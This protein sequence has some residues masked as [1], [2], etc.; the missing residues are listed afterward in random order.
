MAAKGAPARPPEGSGPL[1]LF[2]SRWETDSEDVHDMARLQILHARDRRRELEKALL[3]NFVGGDPPSPMSSASGASAAHLMRPRSA[4][5]G[6]TRPLSAMSRMSYGSV[7]AS[8]LPAGMHGSV[9]VPSLAERRGRRLSVADVLG[10]SLLEEQ[11]DIDSFEAHGGEAPSPSSPPSAP[12]S[13]PTTAPPKKAAPAARPASPVHAFAGGK[14]LEA[15][16]RIAA[17]PRGMTRLA[18]AIERHAASGAE[19]HSLGYVLDLAAMEVEE[20]GVLPADLAPGYLSSVL[21]PALSQDPAET[22]RWLSGALQSL[23]SEYGGA[24]QKGAD[25]A[26]A[27]V[28]AGRLLHV[29]SHQLCA[30]LL[31]SDPA[32]GAAAGGPPR[33]RARLLGRLWRSYA[34]LLE[35]MAELHRLASDISAAELKRLGEQNALLQAKNTRLTEAFL[36]SAAGALRRAG[37]PRGRGRRRAGRAAL[38]AWAGRG[39]AE[40]AGGAA[41]ASEGTTESGSVRAESMTSGSGSGRTGPAD[42]ARSAAA[43]AAVA[44]EDPWAEIHARPPAPLPPADSF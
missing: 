16:A 43:V 12:P 10:G 14:L 18:A 24:V 6:Q 8:S 4:A 21:S 33:A 44:N 35:R 39:G 38:E 37:G 3:H 41:A 34:A 11:G 40:G 17:G 2:Y 30:Q 9:S 13:R 7:S 27:A 32:A 25:P 19:Y 42:S 23:V 28:A 5:P 22:D 26:E 1:A 15:A 20:P 31:A 29:A 36:G